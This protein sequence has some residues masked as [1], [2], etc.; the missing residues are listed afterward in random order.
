MALSTK[1]ALRLP[2]WPGV[3]YFPSLSCSQCLNHYP[4]FLVVQRSINLVRRV[5]LSDLPPFHCLRPHSFPRRNALGCLLADHS[6]PKT[7]FPSPTLDCTLEATCGHRKAQSQCMGSPETLDC[8]PKQLVRLPLLS[9]TVPVPSPRVPS[10]LMAL[11]LFSED[12]RLPTGFLPLS[13]L[14]SHLSC[15]LPL[16]T[17]HFCIQLRTSLGHQILSSLILF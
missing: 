2:L 10:L 17:T 13:P 3:F 7:S 5:C 14:P 12:L 15:L 16:W 1:S 4:W 6:P 11:H 8:D 9:L